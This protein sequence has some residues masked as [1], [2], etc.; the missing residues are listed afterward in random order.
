[1][2]EQKFCH[3]FEFKA[4]PTT[5]V[6]S[7]NYTQKNKCGS[8]VRQRWNTLLLCVRCTRKCATTQSSIFLKIEINSFD[9]CC[10]SSVYGLP[11]SVPLLNVVIAS[12]TPGALDFQTAI[13][14]F[15]QNQ[16]TVLTYAANSDYILKLNTQRIDSC[17]SYYKSTYILVTNA[18]MQ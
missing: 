7:S 3:Y 6:E 9:T 2:L 11:R 17:S 8:Q 1:M 15:S 13:Y 14:Y 16:I 18:H 12:N 10:N 5:Q 4:E